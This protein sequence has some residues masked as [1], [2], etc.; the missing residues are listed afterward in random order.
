LEYAPYS[1][2]W[3]YR[4]GDG[5]N[6][7]FLDND[8]AYGTRG[9]KDN[10]VKQLL[11]N[12]GVRFCANMPKTPELQAIERFWRIIKQRQKTRQLRSGKAS[13]FQLKMM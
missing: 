11:R 8:Q 7:L 13:V 10:K 5:I 9:A 12:A 4:P 1:N 2:G 6:V 3:E